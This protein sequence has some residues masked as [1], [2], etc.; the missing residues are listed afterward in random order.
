MLPVF[1]PGASTR[2][3][4]N[5]L[6]GSM[7]VGRLKLVLAEVSDARVLPSGASKLAV[8]DPRVLA[9]NCAVACCPALPAKVALTFC[10]GAPTF[11]VAAGPFGVMLVIRSVASL[12]VTATLPVAVEDGIIATV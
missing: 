4:Y 12:R 8:T 5:P 10:P 11:R 2:T 6:L 1:A 9:V 7:I 3:V